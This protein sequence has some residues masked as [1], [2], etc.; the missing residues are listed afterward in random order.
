MYLNNSQ[1][2]TYNTIPSPHF[3]LIQ[4]VSQFTSITAYLSSYHLSFALSD[5]TYIIVSYDTTSDRNARI[6]FNTDSLCG[7]VSP[8][9][10]GT[11]TM[12]VAFIIYQVNQIY[13]TNII[14][15]YYNDLS[16]GTRQT[17]PITD[18]NTMYTQN[19]HNSTLRIY[20]A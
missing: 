10:D 4:V 14:S 7:L 20:V 19:T 16:G 5:Y 17:A 18:I 15:G 11:W 8:Q 6:G 9:M 2:L 3:K 12:S 1:I 13:Y